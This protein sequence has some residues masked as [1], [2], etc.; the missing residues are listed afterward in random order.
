MNDSGT[1]GGRSGS[2][3]R[4][5][6]GAC[7]T[8]GLVV[9]HSIATLE[10]SL[11]IARRGPGAAGSLA[12]LL[13][14]W[15]GSL[16]AAA[17]V[18]VALCLLLGLPL[19][20]VQKLPCV[21]LTAAIGALAGTPILLAGFSG[22]VAALANPPALVALVVGVSCALGCAVYL[23]A[24]AIDPATREGSMAVAGALIAPVVAAEALLLAWIRFSYLRGL[25]GPI[26]LRLWAVVVLLVV[27][28]SLLL[29]RRDAVLRRIPSGLACWSLLLLG[30]AGWRMAAPQARPVKLEQAVQSERKIR[31]VVLI[32]VDTLRPDALGGGMESGC[33][34]PAMD[35][36]AGSGVTFESAYA[37]SSWTQ[38]SVASIMTGLSP[39]VHGVSRKQARFPEAATS[40]EDFFHEEGYLTA[41]FGANILMTP[42]KALSRS[43]DVYEFPGLPPLE[44]LATRAVARFRGPLRMS[45]Q[46]RTEG[47]TAAAEA[48]VELH[49]D[50]DFFLWLHYFDPHAPYLPPEE[51]IDEA[52]LGPA[53]RI[54]LGFDED[55]AVSKF[56]PPPPGQQA[57][58]RKMY[59]G[60]VRYVD[61]RV[62]RLLELLRSLRIYDDALIVL[63]SDHG[64]EFWEHGSAFHGHSLYQELIEA[65]L[66]LKLPGGNGNHRTRVSEPVSNVRVAPTILDLSEIEFDPRRFSGGSLKPLWEDAE[67][68]NPKPVFGSHN[69]L[70]DR[71]RAVVLGDWKYIWHP[72]SRRDE[73]YH[74][75]EDPQERMNLLTRETERV[76]QMRVLL[77]EHLSESAELR[78][79]LG[80]RGRSPGRLQQDMERRLRSLGYIE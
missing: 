41:A 24:R 37:T 36:L 3:S 58:L 14:Y 71:Q 11:A 68:T 79:R 42:Q 12:E 44:T 17:A 30:V 5:E 39:A 7:L 60:E 1:S 64:E 70:R 2:F 25:L 6:F 62:G 61:D 19:R 22:G 45:D 38:P 56:M 15:A 73:L 34:S 65:P 47:I 13:S 16:V 78:Q 4:S 53:Y 35:A 26:P 63:T 10:L 50:E 43:F 72:D 77:E 31:H 29:L 46:H 69:M 48:W 52:D 8:A 54:A 18:F 27:A 66:F 28:G 32:T 55:R 74:L 33:E 23:G 20:L 9:I 51:F 59:C 57:M 21:P 76:E 80:I 75:K 49:S 40:L 67:G